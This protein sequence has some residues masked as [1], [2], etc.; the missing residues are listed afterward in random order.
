MVV[1]KINFQTTLG[2][3]PAMHYTSVAVLIESKERNDFYYGLFSLTLVY[4]HGRDG[5]DLKG[6]THVYI[7]CM[8]H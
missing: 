2:R 6:N 8:S 7:C 4:R 3:T 1:E 5:I